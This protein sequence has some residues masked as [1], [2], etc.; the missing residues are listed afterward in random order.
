MNDKPTEQLPKPSS[1]RTFGYKST[2]QISNSS[3]QISGLTRSQSAGSLRISPRRRGSEDSQKLR[4]DVTS[5]NIRNALSHSGERAT[6][7]NSTSIANNSFATTSPTSPILADA[8]DDGMQSAETSHE[9]E[10]ATTESKRSESIKVTKDFL[11]YYSADERAHIS[12]LL[13]IVGSKKKGYYKIKTADNS[14]DEAIRQNLQSIID[15]FSSLHWICIPPL[16]QSE[17][18]YDLA[19]FV[20]TGPDEYLPFQASIFNFFYRSNFTTS[21]KMILFDASHTQT[22][23]QITQEFYQ[24]TERDKSFQYDHANMPHTLLSKIWDDKT[25]KGDAKSIL[26][27]SAYD[28]L[29]ILQRY[30]NKHPNPA[31]DL[32]CAN[33]AQETV[34][35]NSFLAKLIIE[36]F[37]L[38]PKSL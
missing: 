9:N 13:R 14:L 8:D 31:I 11:K 36:E 23:R 10:T 16:T 12:C 35:S 18:S 33:Q 32:F 24:F 3:S 17:K 19:V 4:I 20:L 2:L 1:D 15:I 34:P 25:V 7:T 27:V 21:K 30:L 6:S 28:V 22:K 37:S 29:D 5:K 38:P 26:I